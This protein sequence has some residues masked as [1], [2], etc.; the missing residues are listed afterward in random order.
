MSFRATKANAYDEAKSTAASVKR[1][2][3]DTKAAALAGPISANVIRQLLDKLIS[4]KAKFAEITAIPGIAAY[5]EAQE[6]DSAYDVSAEFTAMTSEVD[7]ILNWV[8]ANIPTGTGGFVLTETWS[9]SGVSVR[10]FS[11]AQ[12]AG[13]RTELDA[14][15]A[16]I[17]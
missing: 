1:L 4:A 12:T 9:T 8:I 2:C 15:I 10:T 7:G 17:D 3:T 11:T 13:L 5:A 14:L 6:G 16:T